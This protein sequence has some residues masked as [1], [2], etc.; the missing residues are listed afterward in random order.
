MSFWEC[1]LCGYRNTFDLNTI[2]KRCYK[3]DAYSATFRREDTTLNDSIP[4]EPERVCTRNTGPCENE[5]TS[6]CAGCI[7]YGYPDHTYAQRAGML[8]REGYPE[9]DWF[10][11][12]WDGRPRTQKL[13]V[14]S[15]DKT[16]TKEQAQAEAKR[17]NSGYDEDWAPH[18]LRAFRWSDGLKG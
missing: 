14:I 12:S 17:Y 4:V 13:N 16:L 8:E 6:W 10:V 18:R 9:D 11:V 3:C 7:W 2:Y 15:F 1:P 5:A